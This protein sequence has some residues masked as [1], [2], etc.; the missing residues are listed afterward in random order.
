MTEGFHRLILGPILAEGHAPKEVAHRIAL[1][2]TRHFEDLLR[3]VEMQAAQS[4]F[5]KRRKKK[6]RTPDEDDGTSDRIKAIRR[7]IAE[8]AY[9][10]ATMAL[11]DQEM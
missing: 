4:S 7:M 5:G 10:K 8:G 11:L 2:Q 6:K 3:R 1:W 9:R